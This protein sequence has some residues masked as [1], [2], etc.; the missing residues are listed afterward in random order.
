MTTPRPNQSPPSLLMITLWTTSLTMF[1]CAQSETAPIDSTAD[2]PPADP[3]ALALVSTA[4]VEGFLG[5][6][7]EPFEVALRTQLGETYLHRPIGVRT[8]EIALRSTGMTQ[9][10]CTSCHIPGR[11]AVNPEHDRDAHQHVVPVHPSAT[12]ATCANCHR[13][14]YVDQL[15]LLQTVESVP[16]D[17]AYRICA[18]CHFQQV[19]AWAGGAHGK[20]L[21]GWQGRRV[22]MGC[23]DCHDPHRPAVGQRIPYPGPTLPATE[24]H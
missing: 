21:G 5:P 19:E 24:R 15:V 2:G 22:V 23:T 16:L 12:G 11:V 17:Q 3:P 4:V 9:Y 7:G 13:S 18:Q 20:R 10:P 6:G 14:G 8:F 1:G